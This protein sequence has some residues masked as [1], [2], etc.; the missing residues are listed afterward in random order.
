MIIKKRLVNFSPNSKMKQYTECNLKKKTRSWA[1]KVLALEN[2]HKR[3]RQFGEKGLK[4]LLLMF[5]Y[6]KVKIPCRPVINGPI[7]QIKNRHS[8]W[9]CEKLCSF[10]RS[11]RISTTPNTTKK[12]CSYS[13]LY[14]NLIWS[15]WVASRRKIK[16]WIWGK[17]V[18]FITE[19][20]VFQ[21]EIPTNLPLQ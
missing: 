8:I 19:S 13:N 18:Q 14:S 2:V 4:F 21:P 10:N 12:K 15:F 17:K 11:W 20:C 7:S 9:G 1:W 6:N 16:I 5:P 3:L